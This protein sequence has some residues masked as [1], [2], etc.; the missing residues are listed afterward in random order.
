MN[1]ITTTT[2]GTTIAA[3][4]IVEGLAEG[5]GE[6]T[7]VL[8]A[9]AKCVSPGGHANQTVAVKAHQKTPVE[10]GQ[11]SFHVVGGA[12]FDRPC[13]HEIQFSDVHVIADESTGNE[14]VLM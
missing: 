12:M 5:D 6:I 2:S 4:G 14:I 13:K 3:S 10:F 8:T 11:A 7:V 1:E 9:T